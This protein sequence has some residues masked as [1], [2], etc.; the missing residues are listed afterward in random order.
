M[1]KLPDSQELLMGTV[2]WGLW[3]QLDKAYDFLKSRYGPDADDAARGAPDPAEL[4]SAVRQ[5]GDFDSPLVQA[6]AQAWLVREDEAKLEHLLAGKR[7]E[8][9]REELLVLLA[10]LAYAAGR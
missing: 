4:L 1:V 3:K 5:L 6:L 2:F 9:G 7:G 10:V 8:L